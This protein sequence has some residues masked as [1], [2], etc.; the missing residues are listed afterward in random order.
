M[1]GQIEEDAF[2]PKGGD[3]LLRQFSAEPMLQV[4]R[5]KSIS[6]ESKSLH[7]QVDV[8][9]AAPSHDV[10]RQTSSRLLW[11]GFGVAVLMF[12]GVSSCV[13]L[14]ASAN[15]LQ[16]VPML[17]F[18]VA[19]PHQSLRPSSPA[20]SGSL[21]S[22]AP[23]GLP[24][25][26]RQGAKRGQ[27]VSMQMGGSVVDFPQEN[28]NPLPDLR[29][30]F[31]N[32]KE[33]MREAFPQ[34]FFKQGKQFPEQ[35]FSTVVDRVAIRAIDHGLDSLQEVPSSV[36]WADDFNGALKPVTP[37][38]H[39]KLTVKSGKLPVDLSGD[40]MR[41]GPNVCVWPPTK[42]T[43]VIDGDGMVHS[44]RIKGGE[45]TYHCKY[46]Q[47]PRHQF[48][49][50]VGEE[51]F[52]RIGE[53]TGLPGL[54]KVMTVA[55]RKTQLAGFEEWETG[56]AN[57]AIAY[58]PAGKL[59]ALNEGGPPFRFRLDEEGVPH[60]MGFDT[61]LD[62]HRKPMS[63]HPKF[64][65]NTGDLYFQGRVVMKENYIA[66]VQD[67]K[68]TE[69]AE[70]DLPTGFH[71][72]MC[73]TKNNVVLIDGSTRFSKEAMVLGK[74]LWQFE[75]SQM[76]RFGVM[77]RSK[78]LAAEDFKWI[79]ASVAAELVH[80]LHAYEEDGKIII[81][82]P[83]SF[84][85]DQ[86][87]KEEG[88]LGGVGP[89]TMHRITVDVESEQ[90]DIQVVPGGEQIVNEFPRIR[91]DRMGLHTRYGFSGLQSPGSDFNFTGV[92][93]WDF[94]K[95]KLAGRIDF[96]PNVVGGEP[97]F[98]PGSGKGGDDDGYIGMFLWDAEK[99]E[100]TWTLFDAQSFSSKPVVELSVPR[101]VPLGFHAAWINE[102]EFQKQL[103]TP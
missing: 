59:W 100:S 24:Q 46:L 41:V 17:P 74:P 39:V 31:P 27:S 13:L 97:I 36:T 51:W 23:P 3:N 72:D 45:A 18:N 15:P 62:T 61:L 86:D 84:Y 81:W 28:T 63:A 50:E 83:L 56:T 98:I 77:P 52:P 60:S 76:L 68:V 7:I 73:I 96:P 32:F 93:K 85:Q 78:K 37:T 47:T 89:S 79:E 88:L 80:V 71:H 90:V 40:Y 9:Q 87:G 69:Y 65:R 11:A 64:D 70:I 44:I 29:D 22:S 101:R 58:N 66:R 92:L 26:V 6:N 102:E 94:D 99:E 19:L 42:R 25:V 34:G 57:T 55:W 49:R 53:Y 4:A 5:Q 21:R 30:A 67:G 48:E 82:A 75:Q 33:K 103:H 54:A 20:S 1:L 95:F 10:P 2:S 16:H 91:D 38:G 35:L 12:I 43:H 14:P 8:E